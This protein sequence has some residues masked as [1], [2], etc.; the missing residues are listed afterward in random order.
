MWRFALTFC[1]AA[2]FASRIT[3]AE[4]KRLRIVTTILPVYCF[5][6]GVVGTNGEVHNLLP[7]NVEPH[8][9]QLS[10]SDIRKLK[11]ADLVIFNGLGLDNWVAKALGPGQQNRMLELGEAFRGELITALGDL[12]MEGEHTRSRDRQHA[13]ANPHIWLDP[14]LAMRSVTNIV[15]AVR[16]LDPARADSYRRNAESYISRL[17]GLDSEIVLALVAVHNKPIL[18]QH[19]AFPYFVRRFQLRQV[20]VVETTP[21]VPPSPRYL[22]DLMKVIREKNVTVL[23]NDPAASPRLIKRIA[24]DAGIRTAELE[25]LESGP[26]QPSAYEEGMRRNAETLRRELAK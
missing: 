26:A 7:P 21:D 17:R 5:A 2:S 18:T 16:K 1:L 15:G 12:E 22:A 19:D 25:T 13:P 9:Y 10:P 6:S 24:H 23:F 14:E 3:A 4:A 11:D 8:D 20:G